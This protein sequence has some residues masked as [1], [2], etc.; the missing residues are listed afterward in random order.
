MAADAGAVPVGEEIV[1]VSGTAEG[2]DTAVVMTA[3]NVHKMFD[4]GIREIIAI[5]RRK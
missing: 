3:A 5:P 2:A 4:I 1:V